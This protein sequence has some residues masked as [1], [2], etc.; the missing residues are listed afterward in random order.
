MIK[1]INKNTIQYKCYMYETEGIVNLDKAVLINVNHDAGGP[2][3]QFIT[4]LAKCTVYYEWDPDI[5]S[6]LEMKEHWKML[7]EYFEKKE[8]KLIIE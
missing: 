6:N 4:N 1:F 3:I 8:E 2:Y 7:V 5:T